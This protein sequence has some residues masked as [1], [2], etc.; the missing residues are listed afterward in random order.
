MKKII[1]LITFLSFIILSV[2]NS[3]AQDKNQAG[4]KAGVSSVIITPEQSLWMAGFAH[5]TSPSDGKLHELWAKALVIE[6]ASGK[7]AV[8]ITTDLSGIPKSI[9]DSIRNRLERRF[10]FSRSQIIFNTSHTHSGPV[11]VD[12]LW[13][14][15][16]LDDT[17]KQ[18]ITS[19][20][21]KFELQIESIV[22][23]ALSSMKPVNI[24]SENG[25]TRF[26]VNR[27]NN[28]ENQID[29][30]TDLKGPSDYAVPV[31]KV[32]DQKGKI[33]ALAFGYA[34]HNTVL[35]GYE[36]SGDYAGYA[37]IALE[38]S[39]P[40]AT[41]LFFQGCGGN[42][43]ALPRK[44]VPLARQYGGELALA[45]DAVLDG[46][47]KNL[48]PK[49]QTAY[50][51]VSLELENAPTKE[52]LANI[53]SKES[54]YIKNWALNMIKRANN[55]EVFIRTYPYPVQ[56]WKLGDQAIV[57]L[58]GEPVVDYAI[59][60]KKILGPD[61]FVMGYS[62]DVMAY[63]PTAEILREG[64]YE[65]HTSQMAF[66]MPAKWKES[67][68]PAI[69]NEIKKLAGQAGMSLKNK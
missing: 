47:M 63:I 23:K 62:N 20:T 66:G 44:S 9:S 64:G 69:M 38:K 1:V 34:C 57:A 49:L 56:F 55:G 41:A 5:R 6:D 2:Q 11:L 37:Q 46:K 32:S 3:S 35:H 45:V 21:K 8:L 13:D 26:A 16:P 18:R 14:L 27:R 22:R 61:L 52:E 33:L 50:S 43:N 68:E 30:Q 39:H 7:Q 60:M 67:I 51:E 42:Q 19:Y 59:N 65:G 24:S 28:I 54:G 25:I 10:K 4:W 29:A 53:A 12:A 17:Q 40:G 36:W 31:L 48:E 15:Y 58:G